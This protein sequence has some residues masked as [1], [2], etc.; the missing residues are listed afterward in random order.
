MAPVLRSRAA[1]EQLPFGSQASAVDS[2]SSTLSAQAQIPATMT[3]TTRPSVHAEPSDPLLSDRERELLEEERRIDEQLAIARREAALRT[4]RA[5][6]E[7]LQ[8]STETDRTTEVTTSH[9]APAQE[10]PSGSAT[11]PS[12]SLPAVN[13]AA[14]IWRT[15]S[16]NHPKYSGQDAT[17][18]RNFLF[19][20]KTNFQLLGHLR[21]SSDRVAYAVSCLQG[22]PKNAWV[23]Y[24]AEQ[25]ADPSFDPASVTWEEFVD[26]LETQLS[27]PETRALA[28]ASSL[29]RLAQTNYETVTQ[30]IDRYTS[31]V[32]DLPYKMD[33]VQ[34]VISLLPKF[35]SEI[36]LAISCQ[37]A[38][39]AT[40]QQLVSTARRIEDSQRVAGTSSYNPSA[41]P[42]NQQND[43]FSSNRSSAASSLLGRNNRST[44]CYACNKEG[45]IQRN[46]PDLYGS[47]KP[48]SDPPPAATT[49]PAVPRGS[50]RCYTCDETGH[51]STYCPKSTCRRCGR[52][53]HTAVRCP[54]ANAND[55]PIIRP[56]VVGA[57]TQ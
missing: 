1:S 42:T 3:R 44:R 14:S 24:I 31:V 21:A 12:L 54:E 7:R 4:K 57:T 40:Y 46:C 55:A 27:D 17:A 16:L 15:S 22:T 18:L 32:A 35:R 5:E 48:S 34:R 36:R 37:A 49:A 2:S 51:I 53:G 28:A 26:F 50:V 29:E 45:H 23:K 38:L 9:A 41:R 19:D 8:S 30:F 25:E 47:S 13:A 33:D 43:A 56:R 39:P 52:A 6:L 11:A 10:L 20:C